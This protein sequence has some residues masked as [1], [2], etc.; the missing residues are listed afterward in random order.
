MGEICWDADQHESG[1]LATGSPP[2][3]IETAKSCY[4]VTIPMTGQWDL[5]VNEANDIPSMEPCHSELAVSSGLRG[6]GR[7]Y[8][9][10]RCLG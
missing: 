8:I 2:V 5:R 9:G 6:S 4:G 10:G 7:E 3:L 1:A